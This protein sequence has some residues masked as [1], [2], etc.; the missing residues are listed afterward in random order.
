VLLLG[1]ADP[2]WQPSAAV[3][4]QRHGQSP[5]DARRWRLPG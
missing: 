5:R 4:Q 3:S 2:P 1:S